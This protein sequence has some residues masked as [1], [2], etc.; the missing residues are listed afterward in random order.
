MAI[1]TKAV[2]SKI[3]RKVKENIH[4][5]MVMSMLEDLLPTIAKAKEK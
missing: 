4:G 2:L 1:D 3:D 5:K